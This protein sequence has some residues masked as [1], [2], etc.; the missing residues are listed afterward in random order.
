MSGSDIGSAMT[1]QRRDQ[2]PA[3]QIPVMDTDIAEVGVR[4]KSPP[5]GLLETI[6]RTAKDDLDFAGNVLSYITSRSS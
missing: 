6:I 2:M 5:Q 4:R 1:E 3:Y